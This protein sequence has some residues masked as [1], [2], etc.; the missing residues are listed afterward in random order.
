MDFA[1][2]STAADDKIT[3]KRNVAKLYVMSVPT[4]S[5]GYG[6]G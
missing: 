3:W 5:Q 4:T 1:G 6:I 2:T